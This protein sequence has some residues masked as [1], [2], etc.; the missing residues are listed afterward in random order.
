MDEK[1]IIKI[2]ENEDR[3]KSNTKRIDEI[4]IEQKSQRD[5]IVS[6]KELATEVKHMREDMSKI[7]RRLSNVEEKPLKRYE[8]IVS[9]IITRYHNCDTG[10]FISQIRIVGGAKYETSM[11]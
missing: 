2:Q 4:E 1:Y 6:V 7:D 10:F 11:E 5:L 3:S 9:L 8:Q